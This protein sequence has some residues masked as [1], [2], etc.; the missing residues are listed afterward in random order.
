MDFLL[1]GVVEVVDDG[2]ALP[3]GGTKQRALLALLALNAP[4]SVSP[5]RLID[6]LWGE[7]PPATAT[8][9]LQIHVSRLRRALAAD[10]IH[11]RPDGYALVVDAD[12]VDAAR[13][14]RLLTD[15]P[16]APD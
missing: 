8:K 1:L 7:R 14:E 6:E 11:T 16:H 5:D 13:F 9:A 12:H 15:A 10:V 3:L 2:R 4:R